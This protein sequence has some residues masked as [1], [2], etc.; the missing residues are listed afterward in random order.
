MCALVF[1]KEEDA[2]GFEFSQE[3]VDDFVPSLQGWLT[4]ALAPYFPTLPAY[5]LRPLV[6]LCISGTSLLLPELTRL[7]KQTKG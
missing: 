5:Y 3:L 7:C 2:G 1:G 6:H 4:G